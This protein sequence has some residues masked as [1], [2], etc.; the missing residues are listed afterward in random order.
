M[1]MRRAMFVARE[2]GDHQPL[3]RADFHQ[4]DDN[5]TDRIE[6]MPFGAMPIS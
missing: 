2:N 1:H 6:W 5:P 3:M 4:P